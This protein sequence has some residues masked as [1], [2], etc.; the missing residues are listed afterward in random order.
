LGAIDEGIM[1]AARDGVTQL[2]QTIATGETIRWYMDIGNLIGGTGL[3]GEI[4]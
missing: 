2:C 1:M 4:R 3:D